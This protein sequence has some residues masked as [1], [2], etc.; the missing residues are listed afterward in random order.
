MTMK[1]IRCKDN[2]QMPGVIVGGGIGWA[3]ILICLVV[4]RWC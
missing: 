2:C 1:C 3:I 4:I